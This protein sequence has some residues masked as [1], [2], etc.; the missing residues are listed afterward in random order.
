MRKGQLVPA[1]VQD[2]ILARY[3]RGVKVR[4]IAGEFNVGDHYPT[5]LAKR[6]GIPLRQPHAP[7]RG[8]RA[9]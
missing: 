2:L 5:D 4:T 6:R 8:L 7:Q 9:A 3:L 1:E